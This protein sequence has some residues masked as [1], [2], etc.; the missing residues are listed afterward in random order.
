MQGFLFRAWDIELSGIH[1]GQSHEQYNTSGHCS[2][3]RLYDIGSGKDVV[4]KIGS[5]STLHLSRFQPAVTAN[6]AQW[7]NDHAQRKKA[8]WRVNH[9]YFSKLPNATVRNEMQKM[10]PRKNA[11]IT[12]TRR[13]LGRLPRRFFTS[14]SRCRGFGV[15]VHRGG[16][17]SIWSEY[18][19]VID[20]QE[21]R[22]RTLA[23]QANLCADNKNS[24]RIV[25]DYWLA[26]E[27]MQ[28]VP[29]CSSMLWL[30]QR[31]WSLQLHHLLGRCYS[32]I[33]DL[34]ASSKLRNMALVAHIGN[35]TFFCLERA[36][37]L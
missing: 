28:G 24:I 18:P 32:T 4:R 7:N 19:D 21:G 22:W 37:D 5:Q 33:K 11:M 12:T 34:H 23:S 1:W 26:V 27:T 17:P 2:V 29:A 9:Q 13:V 16:R 10:P 30:H 36:H 8:S 35:S 31:R 6:S 25:Y 15:T 3:K 14:N 20:K